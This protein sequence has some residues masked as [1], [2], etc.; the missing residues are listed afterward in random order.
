MTVNGD[1]LSL[2]ELFIWD[3]SYFIVILCCKFI[4]V[5]FVLEDEVM[6]LVN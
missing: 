4:D 2:K 5:T 1:D 3:W 6:I